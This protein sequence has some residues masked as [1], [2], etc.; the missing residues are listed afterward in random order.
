MDWKD[1]LRESV[2]IEKE[3][4]FFTLD[5]VTIDQGGD[6]DCGEEDVVYE[7][8]CSEEGIEYIT[9]DDTES[10]DGDIKYVMGDSDML[11]CGCCNMSPCGCTDVICD[12]VDIGEIPDECEVVDRNSYMKIPIHQE[13]TVLPGD[14]PND[15]S[16]DRFEV[17]VDWGDGEITLMADLQEAADNISFKD[18]LIKDVHPDTVSHK[19]SVEGTI[20][21]E[22]GEI[23]SYELAEMSKNYHLKDYSCSYIN[24]DEYKKLSADK[25]HTKMIDAVKD[26][27]ENLGGFSDL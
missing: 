17:S 16:S 9:E 5:N 20:T 7:Y 21:F 8:D 19:M 10:D 22:C 1:R 26:Y 27:L 4:D 24:E 18:Q 3:E 6:S 13:I 2:G 12:V 25:E 15:K 11:T 23:F 14:D